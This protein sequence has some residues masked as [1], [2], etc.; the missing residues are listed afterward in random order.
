MLQTDRQTYSWS[1]VVMGG[2]GW[3]K[4]DSAFKVRPNVTDIQTDSALALY[5]DHYL[6]HCPHHHHHP[7]DVPRAEQ[8][9]DQD[10]CARGNGGTRHICRL[11]L[12]Y[13]YIIVY[14]QFH[15]V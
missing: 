4:G 8:E 6:H 1:H 5:I 10:Q 7:P 3:L 13:N 9:Q 11:F 12:L 15:I 2:Y 14:H